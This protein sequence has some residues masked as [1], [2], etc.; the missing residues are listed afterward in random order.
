MH[1][2]Q[3]DRKMQNILTKLLKLVVVEGSTYADFNK[4]LLLA[5]IWGQLYPPPPKMVLI[6]KTTRCHNPEDGQMRSH[7]SSNLKLYRWV[8]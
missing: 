7:H 8:G 1:Y 6:F 3:Y 4:L 2:G 5:Q